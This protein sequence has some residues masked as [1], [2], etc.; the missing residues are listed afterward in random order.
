[1]KT[2]RPNSDNTT[3]ELRP[4]ANSFVLG[5]VPERDNNVSTLHRTSSSSSEANSV[6]SIAKSNKTVRL[7]NNTLLQHHSQT[8]TLANN[9]VIAVS[10]PQLPRPRLRRSSTSARL[11]RRRSSVLS[12]PVLSQLNNQQPAISNVYKG[13]LFV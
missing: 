1:M 4:I 11:E 3:P 13:F 10:P 8:A 6:D 5:R 12:E 2:I 7:R 9:T